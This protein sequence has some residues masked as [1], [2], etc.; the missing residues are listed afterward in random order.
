[1]H[2]L[3]IEQRTAFRAAV[4]RAA[5][6]PAV[7]TAVENVYIAL[8][9]AIDLR[10]PVCVT[11]GRC[12]RFDEFGHRL[13]VTTMELAAFVRG[14]RQA[15]PFAVGSPQA[16]GCPFQADKLCSVHSIRPFGCRVFF[17]DAT[18][19]EWQQVQ[20]ARFHAELKRLHDELEVP[21]FYMEWRA[22]LK[23]LELPYP[24]VSSEDSL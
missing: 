1:V 12:C 14:L 16:G 9:D 17:C 18:A 22:A 5:V 15:A 13:F 19:S 7:R 2:E 23:A 6:I 20:Y 3:T 8:Q 4:E 11:S 21:Y 10:R 24:R